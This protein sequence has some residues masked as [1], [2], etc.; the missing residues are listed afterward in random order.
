MSSVELV[1]EFGFSRAQRLIT[2]QKGWKTVEVGKVVQLFPTH[3]FATLTSKASVL[4]R[5][6]LSRLACPRHARC[7]STAKLT[8]SRGSAKMSLLPPYADEAGDRRAFSY[9][10][11]EAPGSVLISEPTSLQDAHTVVESGAGPST[12]AN[13]HLGRFATSFLFKGIEQTLLDLR[14]ETIFLD[15]S[16]ATVTDPV[17]RVDG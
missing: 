7:H 15:V 4:C 8:G 13:F 14:S 6:D 2:K 16:A 11:E 5:I 3:L 10:C 17:Q 9:T 1:P 12:R